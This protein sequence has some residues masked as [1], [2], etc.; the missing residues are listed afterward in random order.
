MTPRTG[1]AAR[2]RFQS[3][4]ISKSDLVTPQSGQVQVSGT[5]S[6]RVPGA[7]PSSGQP[8]ASL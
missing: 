3:S 1:R 7:M 2:T 5:S 8:S 6:Q 4:I